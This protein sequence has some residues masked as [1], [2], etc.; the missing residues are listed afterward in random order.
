MSCMDGVFGKDNALDHEQGVLHT[1][2]SVRLNAVTAAW[3]SVRRSIS[4]AR[5]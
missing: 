2:E 4:S 1:A 3:A 5:P